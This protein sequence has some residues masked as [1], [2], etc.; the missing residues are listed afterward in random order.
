MAKTHKPGSTVPK[1]GIV[2]EIGPR[3]GIGDRH[4]TVVTDEPFPPTSKP[5]TTWGYVKPTPRK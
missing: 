5:G 2:R 4:A 3:G 1:S